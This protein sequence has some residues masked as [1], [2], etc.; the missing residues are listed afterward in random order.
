M[1]IRLRPSLSAWELNG[2][3]PT[4]KLDQTFWSNTFLCKFDVYL[5]AKEVEG[6]AILVYVSSQLYILEDYN[7]QV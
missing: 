1:G 6:R 5:K 2:P 7:L 4:L 3:S